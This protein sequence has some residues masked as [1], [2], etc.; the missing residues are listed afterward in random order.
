MTIATFVLRRIKGSKRYRRFLFSEPPPQIPHNMKKFS[1]ST[2]TVINLQDSKNLKSLWNIN[3][4]SNSTRTFLFKLHNNTAGY[5]N[6]VAHFVHGHSN[7]CTF[8]DVLNVAEQHPETP[9]HLFYT[10][11]T[12]CPQLYNY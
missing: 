5:N 6:A 7:N 9:L 12:R 8:C 4:L 1:E 10:A 2:E 3:H 11:G